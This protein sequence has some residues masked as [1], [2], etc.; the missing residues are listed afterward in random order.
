[1]LEDIGSIKQIKETLDQKKI[2]TSFIYNSLKVVNLIKVSTKD[3]DLLR[4]GITRFS[5]KFISLECL[6]TL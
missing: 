1:M 6:I 4:P 2:I 5:T 3:K